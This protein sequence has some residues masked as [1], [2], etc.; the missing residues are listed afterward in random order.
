M[1]SRVFRE[2]QKKVS[3]ILDK[4][5][6]SS[7]IAQGLNVPVTTADRLKNSDHRVYVM[8]DA[9]AG[10]GYVIIYVLLISISKLLVLKNSDDI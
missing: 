6:V 4:I 9:S 10:Q 1:F 7:G 2:C 5:G 3:Y 8:S